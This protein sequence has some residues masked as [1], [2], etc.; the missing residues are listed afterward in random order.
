MT[1]IKNSDIEFNIPDSESQ[2]SVTTSTNKRV[3]TYEITSILEKRNKG[4]LTYNNTVRLL[5]KLGLSE[6]EARQILDD[7]DI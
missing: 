2:K 4:L 1:G 7:K 6:N 3:S 5:E